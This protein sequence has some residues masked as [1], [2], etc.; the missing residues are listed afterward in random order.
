MLDAGVGGMANGIPVLAPARLS[1]LIETAAVN[2]IEPPMVDA[3]EPA[4][5][6]AAVAE[7]GPPMGA[8][9]PEQAPPSLTVAKENQFFAEDFDGQ[10]RAAR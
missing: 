8:V 2:V 5:F 6:Y 1:R 4:V 9:E 10:G 3:P 7:V